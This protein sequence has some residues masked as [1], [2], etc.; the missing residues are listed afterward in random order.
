MKNYKTILL[1]ILLISTLGI[2]NTSCDRIEK[3][4]PE[5]KG[6]ID[7]SL[8]PNGD[9]VDYNWPSWTQ[10]TN[11]LQN[12]LLEDYTGHTCPNCPAA[13]LVAEGIE[14]SNPERVYVVSIHASPSNAFQSVS[15]PVFTIDFTTKEG[16]TYVNEIPNF[17]ANPIG[18]INRQDG[19]LS[20]TLWYLSSTWTN[21][22]NS[23][24]NNSPK[25]IM[26]LKKNY[27]PQTRGVFIHTESEFVASTPEECNLVIYLI[28]NKVISP[29]KL[30]NGTTDTQYN[31][32]NVLSGTINGAWGTNIG[33]NFSVGDKIYNHFAI[34]LPDNNVDTTYN[35]SNL[36]LISYIYNKNT[37][38]VLQVI[39][40]NL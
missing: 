14:N 1:Y 39:K 30:S 24:L 23:A 26:Q 31:H 2:Y 27:Y 4:I 18:T 8:F 17:F 12:V 11:N 35:I 5:K 22:V 28:R 37:Y 6:G 15:P 38:E 33:E 13:A 10:N 7:W 3:P 29:Q 20:N 32:H 9:S 40:T 19:G 16:N 34:K 25:A 36:S 21:E